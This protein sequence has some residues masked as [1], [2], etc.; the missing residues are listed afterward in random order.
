MTTSLEEW[1]DRVYEAGGDADELEKA[2]DSWARD[3]DRQLWASGNPYILL[4][5]GLAARHIPDT[6]AR[7]LDAGCGTGMMAKPLHTIGFTDIVG[8]DA[9]P[10]MLE[11][12]KR[13][14]CYSALHNLRLGASIALPDASFDAILA[15][16]VLTHGHAPAESLDGLLALARPGTPII[17]SLSTPAFEE[18]GFGAKIKALSESGAWSLVEKT[19]LF[20]TYPF[21]DDYADL[22]HWVSVYRKAG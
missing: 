1:L 22:R 4:M 13:K 5:T 3:Y 19:P 17:F 7:I 16:G 10:G 14:A 18:A 20:R 15:A 11:V 12:A 21:S 6:A 2:Y 9:S 8:L